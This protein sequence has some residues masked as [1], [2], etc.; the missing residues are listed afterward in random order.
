[1]VGSLFADTIKYTYNG[2]LMV[3]ENITLKRVDNKYIH[4]ITSSK[5]FSKIECD[6]VVEITSTNGENIEFSCSK[7]ST[8]IQK[9]PDKKVSGT[10]INK[11]STLEINSDPPGAAIYIGGNYLDTTPL[12]L[13]DFPADEYEVSIKLTNFKDYTELVKLQPRG[14][15]KISPT[16]ECLYTFDCA[17]VCGGDAKLDNCGT[18]DSDS[19]NDCIQ[20]CVGTWGGSLI[21]D[22]CGICGGD[23]SSCADCANVPNGDKIFDNCGTCDSDSANDCIRDCAGIWGG[24][25][26][27]DECGICGGDNSSCADCGGVPNGDNK[28]D[29]CGTCDSDSANDC[30][31]DCT[32][33]WGGSLIDDECGFCGGDNSICADECGVPNGNNSS[34]T[35][36]SGVPNGDNIADNCGTCDS[37]SANNCIQDCA[38]TWGGSLVVD[39]HG[40]CT[41]PGCTETFVLIIVFVIIASGGTVLP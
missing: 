32:G 23:N 35:D 34:C 10:N 36:C 2:E 8:V 3:K 19:A 41:C 38:G 11:K 20:D 9:E 14:N 18:C 40:L 27:D 25:L 13:E 30:I 1:M 39:E 12:I 16:L 17:G 5:S 31:R 28:S 21:D 15:I 4:Y 6:K 7:P 22:E 37:D 24:S 26:I 29:N 33:S